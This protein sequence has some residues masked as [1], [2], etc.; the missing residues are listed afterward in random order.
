MEK[1]RQMCHSLRKNAFLILKASVIV[2]ATIV[3][4]RQD[5][6]IVFTDALQSET[7]SHIIAVA[8]LFGY[9]IIRKR[10]MLR[11]V[12]PLE[13]HN[14]PK[15]TRYL[16]TI[17]GILLA[18]TAVLLYWHG[19]YTFTPVEYH[20]LSL[21][22][23]VSG[24]CLITFNPQT[25]RQLAF[26][27]AFLLFLTPPP[28]EILYNVGA[29]LQ[30]LS[31]EASNGIMN[32]V[33][34]S[35]TLSLDTGS[36]E[37]TITQPNG[38]SIPFT[39]DIACSGIY[40]LIGFTIFAVFVAYITRDK[41]WK[42]T[43]L[44]LIGLPLV[45]SLNILRITIMLLLGYYYS[46]ETA[47]Q[48]FHLF[49]GWIL[50][51]LGTLLLLIISEKIFKTQ[52]FTKP[53]K[54]CPHYNQ[55]PQPTQSF[56][57]TC[58]RI[59]KPA[60]IKLTKTDAAKLSAIILGVIL[61]NSIQAPVFALNAQPMQ[62]SGDR[63][64]IMINTPTGSQLREILPDENSSDYVKS[65]NYTLIFDHRDTDFEARAKQDMSLVYLYL[66][67]DESK[68][69]IWVFIEIAQ[70][71]SSLHRWETC[72][73]TWPLTHG[74]QPKVTQIELRDI[75]LLQNPLIISRYFV[76]NQT[77]TNEIQAVLYWYES[78]TFTTNQTGQQKQIKISLVAYPGILEALP[79]IESQLVSLATAI[80][81]NWQP[82]KTWSQLTILISQYGATLAV[83]TSLILAI[84]I[85]FFVI[86]TRNQRKTNRKTYEKLSTSNKQIIDS[87]QKT[88][89]TTTPTLNN[90]AATYQGT[91][92]KAINE[93]QLLDKLAELENTGI[94]RSNIAN[95]QD[96]PTQT[97][98]TQISQNKKHI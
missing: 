90:I 50:I 51:F 46:E 21:P 67:N 92:K 39:V 57:T 53:S 44:L 60:A 8:L 69:P 15:E 29:T 77:A 42:K 98:K 68:D 96:E 84:L 1:L 7:T 6:A 74:S 4:F 70:T 76:F 5:L 97:W 66:P 41:L 25:F 80:T 9:L 33:G 72:L 16:A 78:A 65:A 61:L 81:E 95:E 40:S 43:T 73:I 3:L 88:Q 79:N 91:T 89:K 63:P 32:V 34:I 83:A 94:I 87:I 12:I 49:G 54:N 27:I 18:A 56:C 48:A 35:S 45:Y 28:S 86:E 58:G 52:I 37:I 10:K 75:Q 71:R 31:A 26:P 24:L 82:I 11:A 2:A 62:T 93:L 64:L 13:N 23:F 47:I 85:I 14:Q 22:I 30:I 36:P 19:S 17:A 59:L 55:N 38:S 20:M